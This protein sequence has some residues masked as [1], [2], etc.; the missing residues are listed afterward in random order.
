M[1]SYFNT[2]VEDSLKDFNVTKDGLTSQQVTES[3]TKHGLNALKETNS[4]PSF[5]K[6]V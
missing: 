5:F 1:K 2:N 4:Y 6:S 3:L